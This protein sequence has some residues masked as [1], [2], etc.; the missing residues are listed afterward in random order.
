MKD[1]TL[2]VSLFKE[3][4]SLEEVE[5]YLVNYYNKLFDLAA[6]E[7]QLKFSW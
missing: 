7:S 4:K 2:L 5:E 3:F 1:D 6:Y